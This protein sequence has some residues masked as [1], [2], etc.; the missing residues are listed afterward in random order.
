MDRLLRERASCK[1]GFEGA[2][3]AREGFT[4]RILVVANR[5]PVSAVRRGEES[6]SLK[7]SAGGLVSAF[8][9]HNSN[10]KV[11]WFLHTPFPSFEI[12]NTLPSRSDIL[13]AVLVA[14]LVG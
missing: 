4:Q 14:D 2:S 5:L 8:S 1:Y 10:M 13:H 3:A 9:D 6:W 11:G 12:Y 7:D